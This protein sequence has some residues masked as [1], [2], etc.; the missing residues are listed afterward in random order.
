MRQMLGSVDMRVC[1]LALLL[2]GCTTA[3][4]YPFEAGHD[5][6]FILALP[7]PAKVHPVCTIGTSAAK[8]PWRKLTKAS[9]VATIRVAPGTHD[10]SV[11]ERYTR[12]GASTRLDVERD[13]W[14]VV[15]L[16]LGSK[17]GE[18]KVYE[19]PPRDIDWR[20]LIA[21]PR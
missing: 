6:H 19:R 12:S 9:E 21:V 4:Y 17:D 8:P 13:L 11:W 16:D 2:A 10:V 14:L 7:G 18:I 5:V 1:A 20:P 3:P 15:R